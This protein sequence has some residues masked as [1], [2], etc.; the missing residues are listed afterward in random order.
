MMKDQFS[1]SQFCR[2]KI[3]LPSVTCDLYWPFSVLAF[4]AKEAHFASLA[5]ALTRQITNTPQKKVDKER[6]YTDRYSDPCGPYSSFFFFWLQLLP[7]MNFDSQYVI[8][9]VRK[10]CIYFHLCLLIMNWQ[11]IIMPSNNLLY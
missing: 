5:L 8:V 9:Y 3:R 6:S 2:S 4:F 10:F 11:L 1:T 7:V